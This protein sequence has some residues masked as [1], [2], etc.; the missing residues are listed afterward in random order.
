MIKTKAVFLRN[1]SLI[2]AL[3]IL[4]GC[5]A[6]KRE[7]PAETQA[8]ADTAPIAEDKHDRE[9]DYMAA[10]KTHRISLGSFTLH[11]ED[12]IYE[13]ALLRGCAK[14]LANDLA[15]LESAVGEPPEAVTVY[16]VGQTVDN[17]PA[18]VGTEVFCT[19][20]DLDVGAYRPALTG[21]AY[22]LPAEWQRTGLTAYVFEE[23][24][25]ESLK[26]YYA[27]GAHAFTA[28]CSPLHLSPLTTETETV[29][30]ARSTARSIAAFI[31]ENEGFSAFRAAEDTSGALPAWARGLGLA[32]A[33]VLPQKNAELSLMKVLPENGLC[34]ILRVKNFTVNVTNDGWTQDAD[35]LYAWLCDYFEGMELVLDRIRAEAPSAAA[36]A[37]SRFAEP[38]GIDLTDGYTTASMTDPYRNHIWLA[39]PDASWHET[40]HILFTEP[41]GCAWAEWQNE[42]M[43]EHFSYR[44]AT[45]YAPI[46]YASEGFQAYLD[47]FAD[48]SGREADADDLAFHNSVWNLYA[49]LRSPDVTDGDDQEAYYRAYGI[50]SLLSQDVIERKQVRIKYDGSVASKRGQNAGTKET[51]GNALSYPEAEVLFEYLALTYGTDAVIEA[52]LNAVPPEKAFGVSYPE[53][54]KAAKAHY[55]ELYSEYMAFGG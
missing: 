24:D 53:L 17:C 14:A 44:A 3:L 15:A 16:L 55:A 18:A 19:A 20:E 7:E 37:E 46:Y 34:C 9:P 50:C 4:C 52:Y 38:I 28:S 32:E 12:R 49:A 48:V 30:A 27:D 39:G 6:V 22:G 26:T 51:D 29:R 41:E 8:S 43:A 54:L 31:I 45:A 10:F 35:T 23:A 36:V 47:F 25:D 1:V 13:E 2:L 42:G 11:M 33:P 5:A 21:A 40:V